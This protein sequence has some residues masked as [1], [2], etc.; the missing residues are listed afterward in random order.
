LEFDWP[1][2]GRS[3]PLRAIYPDSF[4]RL[5]PIVKLRGDPST[6][7]PRHCS[8]ID[9]NLCLLGRDSRQWR[10]KWTLR[11]LLEL[12]LQSALTGGGEEDQQGEPAEYWWNHCGRRGSY[13]LVDSSWTLGDAMSGT[14]HMRYRLNAADNVPEVQAVITEIRDAA[15]RVI[16]S[17]SGA[18][19][20]GLEAGK[21]ITIPWIFI[22]E[23]ILPDGKPQGIIN[24][25]GRFATPPR[26][27]E[28]S[29]SQPARWFAVLYKMEVGFQVDGMGW[30]F[31]FLYGPRRVFRPAKPG[32]REQ[33]PHITFLPTYRAGEA[34]L[35][36]RVPAVRILRDRKVA[37]VGVGAVGAPLAVELARNGCRKLHL[38]DHDVVE[39]G[40]SIRWPLGG[41]AWGRGK[42]ESLSAFIRREYPWTEVKEHTHAIGGFVD[43][44]PEA[45]DDS[46]FKSILSDVDLV[47]DGTASYGIST[48]L[49]DLCRAQGIPLVCL[50]ASPP[51]EGGTVARFTPESGCPTCLEFAYHAGSIERPPGFDEERGLQQPPGCAERTFT[52]S[53]YDL[54]ELSLQAV[55]LVVET[56]GN[57]DECHE[58]IVQSLSFLVNGRRSPPAWRVDPLPKAEGCSCAKTG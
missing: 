40:N 45:G 50:Y 17:W 24:L 46:V 26:V 35:S 9:G 2:D 29:P 22:D 49:S 37:V 52:G 32:K 41:S 6:F 4:P 55:R 34:D 15:D 5:R 16:G 3:I 53:S 28:L 11:D 13:C 1:L 58:S 31:P 18:V 10:Q 33:G 8:P 30:L 43:D 36:T 19:P 42:A 23:T 12:Q 48:I 38:L 21:E 27:L 25:M 7:P 14:L 39:P 51:V 56:L 47:V 44:R 20:A 57:P 54:Q